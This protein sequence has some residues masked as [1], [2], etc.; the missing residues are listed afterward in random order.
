MSNYTTLA[1]AAVRAAATRTVLNAL[2]PISESNRSNNY[3]AIVL[4]GVSVA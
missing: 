2:L 3:H 4:A 1:V